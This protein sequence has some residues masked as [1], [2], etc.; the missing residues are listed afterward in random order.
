M[1]NVHSLAVSPQITTMI[2]LDHL[3][4]LAAFHRYHV[5]TPRWRKSAIVSIA[6]SALEIHAQ[7]E[8]EI[9]YPALRA[10]QPTATIL[11]KSVPEHQEI[12][13]TIAKLRATEPGASEVDALF[14]TLMREVLH[15][16]ADEETILLPMAERL[17]GPD[18]RQLGARMNAR[19]VQLL[20]KRPGE[21]AK[22]SAG[23][24]P[25]ATIAIA[26]LLLTAA[27]TLFRSRR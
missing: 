13:E 15:H 2:R 26:G 12:R 18:L 6:C 16:V 3:H 5:D 23:A 24:F 27:G 25:L 4:V 1:M 7:L 11:D 22:D 21:I 14:M 10:V 9:F 19:R 20:A 8:E 17:L